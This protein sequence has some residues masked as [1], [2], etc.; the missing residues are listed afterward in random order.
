MEGQG[1]AGQSKLERVLGGVVVGW[2]AA[3][4]YLGQITSKSST[5]KGSA[6]FWV[7]QRV[8]LCLCGETTTIVHMS[9]T[10]GKKA[11]SLKEDKEG[12]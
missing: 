4:L 6:F 9:P 5:L 12:G 2:L 11:N 1:V 3:Q 7:T 8:Q 10:D